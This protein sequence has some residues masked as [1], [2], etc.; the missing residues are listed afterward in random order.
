MHTI[1]SNNFAQYKNIMVSVHWTLA[2]KPGTQ[3]STWFLPGW[4]YS[5]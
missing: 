4:C 2:I 5:P 1:Q 3:T